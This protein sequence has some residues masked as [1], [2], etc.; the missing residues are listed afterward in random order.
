MR[1]G[2]G[3]IKNE[4]GVWHVRKKVP[5]ALE[6]AAASSVLSQTSVSR[7]G[8]TARHQLSPAQNNVRFRT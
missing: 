3:L 1:V 4:H 6:A 8:R 7:R 2:M 5:K